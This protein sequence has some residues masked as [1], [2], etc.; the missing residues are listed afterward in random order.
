M[1][2]W[3]RRQAGYVS[4][5]QRI[6]VPPGYTRMAA[7]RGSYA[8]WLRH[9]PL[10]PERTPVRSYTKEIILP[11]THRYLAAVVDL[12]VGHRDRQHC[13]DSI[14]RL[15]GEFLFASSRADR[16][17]FRWAGRRRFGYSMWR[18]GL[19]PV[20]H[21]RTWSFESKA[22][23]SRGYRSYRRYL[24]YMFSWT[25]TQHMM[26]EPR[27]QPESIQAGDFFIQGGS[28][29]HAVIVLDLARSAR[30]KLVGLIGQGFIPAQDLHVL[31]G[32]RG[33]V[34]F[35]LDAAVLAIKTPLWPAFT[36]TDL[37]RFRY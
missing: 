10:L 25:G 33:A 18:R 12:D 19:R 17:R 11:G 7:A 20:K 15:R 29:G 4:L 9:L 14:M 36:W 8:Y 35:P 27:V 13:S 1:Y 24:G 22:R 6:P 26:A 21:G 34:W 30:G 2:R 28:P 37:R 16:A 5:A 23:P 3:S 32:E 31:R